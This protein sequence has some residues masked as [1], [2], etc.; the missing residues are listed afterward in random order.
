MIALV[1]STVYRCCDRVLDCQSV[2]LEPPAA[3]VTLTD[4]TLH[5]SALALAGYPW[6]EYCCRLMVLPNL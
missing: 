6:A 1:E 4:R 3:V 5:Y 2:T